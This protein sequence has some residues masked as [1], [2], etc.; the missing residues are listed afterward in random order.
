MTD[1]WK[2]QKKERRKKNG[3][4]NKTIDKDRKFSVLLGRDTV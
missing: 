3:G 1:T 4:K 2:D